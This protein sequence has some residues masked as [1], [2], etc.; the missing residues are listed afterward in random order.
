MGGKYSPARAN[1]NGAGKIAAA[2]GGAIPGPRQKAAAGHDPQ[3]TNERGQNMHI[4]MAGGGTG[5]HLFPG[6]ALARQ[7]GATRPGIEI[8]FIGTAHGLDLEIV[9]R[10]GYPIDVVAAGRGSPLNW[11]HPSNL[12]RFVTAVF[13]S[14]QLLRMYRPAAVVA[15]GGFAAAAPGI[16]ARLLGVPLVILEQN[17]VPGKVNRLLGRWAERVY[18]QFRDARA[19]FPAGKAKFLD[20]GTPLREKIYALSQEPPCRGE[21]LLVVGGSQGAARLN[22]IVSQAVPAIVARLHCPIIHVTGAADEE[23]MRALYKEKGVEVEVVGFCSQMEQVLKRARLVISRA[24][25]GGIAD[26]AAAGLPSILVPLPTAAANHQ[27]FNAKWLADQGAARLCEQGALTPE[28]LAAEVCA[29]WEDA[30]AREEMAR[31]ARRA[32]RPEAAREIADDILALLDE[33]AGAK[34]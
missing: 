19:H 31:L 13:Q 23:R 7:L 20:F 5:G 25:A 33:R 1:C 26:V 16:A 8:T 4:I 11:R 10:T 27:Y 28:K 17:T 30:P 12:P 32:A 14:V 6:L 24:G 29:L 21:A 34:G 22:E 3:T 18:L 9:P 2:P 15:L